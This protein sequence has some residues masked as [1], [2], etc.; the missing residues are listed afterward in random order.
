M[1]SKSVVKFLSWKKD[2]IQGKKLLLATWK[3]SGTWCWGE[4]VHLYFYKVE[5]A[6]N[7]CICDCPLGFQSDVHTTS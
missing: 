7:S 2:A 3:E 4:I 5:K 6:L 1:S